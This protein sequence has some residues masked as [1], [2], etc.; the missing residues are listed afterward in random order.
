M[1][2]DDK[3]DSEEDSQPE[4][5]WFKMY[6]G[7]AVGSLTVHLIYQDQE[8]MTAENYIAAG[9][10]GFLGGVLACGISALHRAYEPEYES[11]NKKQDL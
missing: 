11:Q 9:V 8:Y 7:T 4:I 6:L 1:S 10:A 2:V 5:D 3:V